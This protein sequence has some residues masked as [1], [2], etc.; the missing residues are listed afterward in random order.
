MI[1]LAH[2]GSAWA[3]AFNTAWVWIGDNANSIT[4][5]CAII[6]LAINLGCTA[7]KYM[8]GKNED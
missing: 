4:A 5:A 2:K 6:G 1:D 3:I 7:V 8:R